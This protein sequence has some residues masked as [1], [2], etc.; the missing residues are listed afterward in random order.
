MRFF[1]IAFFFRVSR[2]SGR[3]RRPISAER[4]EELPAI[5]PG[6]P[7]ALH[8]ADRARGSGGASLAPDADHALLAD[9]FAA[10]VRSLYRRCDCRGDQDGG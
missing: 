8:R 9:A 2:P 4:T 7:H 3:P 10:V 1:S 5:R 6:D